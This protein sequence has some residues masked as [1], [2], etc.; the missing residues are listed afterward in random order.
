MK[1]KVLAIGL[2][3]LVAVGVSCGSRTADLAEGSDPHMA[4]GEHNMSHADGV[5]QRGDRVMGFDHSRTTHHFRLLKDGGTI[6][7][8]VNDPGDAATREQIRHHLNYVSRMFSAGNFEA[9]M[10]I[11]DREPPG[12]PTLK[13]LRREIK[14]EFEPTG[15]GGRVRITTTNPDA[16]AAVHEFLRFQIQDHQTGDPVEVQQN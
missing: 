9:P 7:V 13:N 15:I 4:A 5:N 12:V 3:M 16:L 14:Y 11:H 2:A 1:N 6:E 10:L 8:E